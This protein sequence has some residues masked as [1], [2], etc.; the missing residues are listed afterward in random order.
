MI[1]PKQQKED[2]F[3]GKD[4]TRLSPWESFD[5]EDS[6]RLSPWFIIFD[7]NFFFP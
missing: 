6:T 7:L 4:T 5:G 3:D 2:S 1:V